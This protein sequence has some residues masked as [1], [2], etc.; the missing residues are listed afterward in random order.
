MGIIIAFANQKGGVAKTTSTFN[1]GVTLAKMG[2]RVLMIDL[3]PQ[4]SL[5][6]CSGLEPYDY[7]KNIVGLLQGT[8]QIRES[9][10]KLKSNLLIVTSNITLASLEMGLVVR[11]NREIILKK[12]L[13]PIQEDFDYILLDCPP[14]LS[15]LTINALSCADLVLIPSETDYL[16][17]RGIEQ[18]IDTIKAVKD[19]CNNKL[20]ILGVI[21]TKYDQRVKDDREVLQVLKDKYNVI[22]I[23][24]KLA[25]AKKGVYEGLAVVEQDSS[26]GIAAEYERISNYIIDK[27]EV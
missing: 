17:Y 15:I 12:A 25:I 11:M 5:T 10:Q 24:K 26:N 9:I 16:S 14:Q 3:D 8:I 22:S 21:A 18:L 27:C 19:E 13:Q 23:I 6:I 7:D 1:V 20:K 2:K 4:A